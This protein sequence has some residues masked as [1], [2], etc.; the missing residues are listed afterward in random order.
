M[1]PA[2]CNLQEFLLSSTVHVHEIRRKLSI[3][4][5]VRSGA[6]LALHSPPPAA[7]LRGG[8]QA[9][10]SPRGARAPPTAATTRLRGGGGARAAAPAAPAAPGSPTSAHS[11]AAPT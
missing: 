3:P 5:P 10:L 6:H 2:G 7:A 1:L 9:G 4:R 8:A 11:A